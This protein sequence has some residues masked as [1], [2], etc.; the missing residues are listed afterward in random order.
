MS[1]VSR[2]KLTITES[3]S[4][5][6]SNPAT[7]I[8]IS[9]AIV[10]VVLNTVI[11]GLYGVFDKWGA[12]GIVW[13]VVAVLL[14]SL[15]LALILLSLARE[16]P[17][18]KKIKSPL[19][20]RSLLIEW[21]YD[22]T[23]KNTVGFNI[24]IKS[25]SGKFAGEKLF[26]VPPRMNFFN[27]ENII[28][29]NENIYGKLS[30][31]VEAKGESLFFKRNSDPIEVEIYNSSIQRIKE[32]KKLR[33]GV[34]ADPAEHFFCYYGRVDSADSKANLTEWQGFDIDLCRLIAKELS[35]D[36]DICVNEDNCNIEIVPLFYSWPEVIYA[37]NNFDVDFS[38][39]S[40]TISKQRE[41]EF[42]I[43][44]SSPYANAG[45]GVVFNK[46]HNDYSGLEEISVA[47]LAGK[48]IGVH[49]GTT[50]S[51]LLNLLNSTDRFNGRFSAIAAESNPKLSSMLLN[52][53]V[54]FVVYDYVRAFSLADDFHRV[55]RL[56]IDDEVINILGDNYDEF[57]D[58]YGVAISQI[59][60][61]LKEK[62]DNII[63]LKE[64]YIE[65]ILNDRIK[66][67]YITMV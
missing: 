41:N 12:Q 66:S 38:V 48:K 60:N 53:E 47:S 16:R 6:K 36:N 5:I 27:F 35:H 23:D 22:G 11:G 4:L 10:A 54:D 65:D 25:L 33:I 56:N 64:K 1:D 42:N 61:D 59:N 67:K 55:K 34:H 19:L 7:A 26:D 57:L 51:A 49:Q 9:I 15:I 46:K 21:S 30:I 18:I 14:L 62:I 24:K 58:G 8:P 13:A 17:K 43:M 31:T 50:S 45:L 32:T 39:A 40:I 2:A 63:K 3:L 29:K 20:S 44:F 28:N 37:P 52:N